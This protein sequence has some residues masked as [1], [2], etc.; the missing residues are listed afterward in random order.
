MKDQDGSRAVP[1]LNT[2]IISRDEK[3]SRKLALARLLL[4]GW[5]ESGS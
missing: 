2:D 4:T 1:D 5:F 3:T